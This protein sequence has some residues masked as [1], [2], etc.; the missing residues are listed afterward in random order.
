MTVW[1]HLVLV[2]P[3]DNVEGGVG[4]VP[5]QATADCPL[6]PVVQQLTLQYQMSTNYIN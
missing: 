5:G 4:P 2:S 3:L 6:V 1:S